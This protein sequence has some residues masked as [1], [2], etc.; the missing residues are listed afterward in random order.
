MTPRS[1]VQ[2]FAMLSSEGENVPFS[3]PVSAIGNVEDWLSDVEA[4]MRSSLYD[5][6]KQG[7]H[8]AVGKGVG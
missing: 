2:M 1:P 8:P 3:A 6:T 5:H 7:T 4:M